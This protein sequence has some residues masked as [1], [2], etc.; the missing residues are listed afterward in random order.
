MLYCF[1]PSFLLAEGCFGSLILRFFDSRSNMLCVHTSYYL[2]VD[3]PALLFR[4]APWMHSC[5]FL[6]VMWSNRGNGLRHT[7]VIGFVRGST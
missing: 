3:P 6:L 1:T 4:L 5:G 2:E 7:A